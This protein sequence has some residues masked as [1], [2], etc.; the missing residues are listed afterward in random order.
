M[1]SSLEEFKFFFF[2]LFSFLISGFINKVS[3]MESVGMVI[4]AGYQL[5]KITA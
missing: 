4:G 2:F 5:M 3:R 1:K